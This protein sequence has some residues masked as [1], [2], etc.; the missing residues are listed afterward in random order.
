MLINK[1]KLPDI[2]YIL[3][4]STIFALGIRELLG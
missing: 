1:I 2:I 3:P 4:K